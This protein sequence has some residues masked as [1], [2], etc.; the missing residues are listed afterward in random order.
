MQFW[1]FFL[2]FYVTVIPCIFIL[3]IL[4]SQ[5]LLRCTRVQLFIYFFF[6]LIGVSCNLIYLCLYFVI[7]HTCLYIYINLSVMLTYQLILMYKIGVEVLLFCLLVIILAFFIF[8]FT[9]D[10]LNTDRLA[11]RFLMYLS[12]FIFSILYLF[13]SVD[14]INLLIAWEN[15]GIFSYLL[16]TFYGYKL[17]AA[18]A[19]IKTFIFARLSD[20]LILFSFGGLLYYLHTTVIFVT[21]WTTS[22]SLYFNHYTS[23]TCI[24]CCLYTASCCK[25]AQLL[26]MSWLTDAMEAPTPASAFIHSSTLVIAGVYLLMQLDYLWFFQPL[27]KQILCIIS[28]VSISFA[29]LVACFQT[30]VKRL[31]AYSTISQIGYLFANIC[32]YTHAELFFYL[33]VHAFNKAILFITAGYLIHFC[34]GLTTLRRMGGLYRYTLIYISFI[35]IIVL[36]LMGVPYFLGF[37]FKELFLIQTPINNIGLRCIFGSFLF[38]F[39]LTAAYLCKLSYF[40]YFAYPKSCITALPLQFTNNKFNINETLY[41]YNT[42]FTLSTIWTYIILWHLLFLFGSGLL[43]FLWM[44]DTLEYGILCYIKIPYMLY[45]PL[46]QTSCSFISQQLIFNIYFY[47]CIYISL[48]AYWTIIRIK[49][50]SFGFYYEF[51]YY[52]LIYYLCCYHGYFY[53]Y[54][55][56]ILYLY[57]ILVC[58]LVL[59]L[60]LYCWKFR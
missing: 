58:L 25:S 60:F 57:G 48:C 27:L 56:Y 45:S 37:Y 28:S 17:H 2:F 24:C 18:R 34:G 54:Y 21:I 52:I 40:I 44:P 41:F 35:I 16:I 39:G 49:Y 4:L 53:L 5:F 1:I 3:F 55:F 30:D 43:Y 59:G 33:W 29:A 32:V 14:L 46:L 38:S 12:G 36:N 19:A 9:L 13:C 8:Y 11:I 7:T 42:L 51:A 10:Y 26:F 22:Y 6:I 15:L 50:Y 23:M 31:I 47:Y 20:C